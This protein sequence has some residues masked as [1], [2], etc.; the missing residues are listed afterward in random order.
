MKWLNRAIAVTACASMIAAVPAAA[1]Y[2]PVPKPAPE[3][4]KRCLAFNYMMFEIEQQ[5]KSF[6][7][8]RRDYIDGWRDLLLKEYASED[9]FNREFQRYYEAFAKEAI[10][11]FAKGDEASI[12]FVSNLTA[13]CSPYELENFLPYED[14]Y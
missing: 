1:Q 2:N 7:R 11:V 5:S 9:F 14:P 8:N 3:V 10:E 4:M 13:Q 6:E 12:D